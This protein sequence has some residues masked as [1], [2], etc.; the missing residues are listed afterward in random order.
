M[1]E[2]STHRSCGIGNLVV[3]GR[4]AIKAILKQGLWHCVVPWSDS[5]SLKMTI[6]S[7]CQSV[8]EHEAKTSTGPAD[9]G[10]ARYAL[11]SRIPSHWHILHSQVMSPYQECHSH[12]RRLFLLRL[13]YC[14]VHT[15]LVSPR[16]WERRVTAHST[17]LRAFRAKEEARKPN[18]AL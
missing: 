7:I 5:E 12:E 3:L 16:F 6:I 8:D 9:P 11:E 13:W 14:M 15:V 4:T 17:H 2:H 10:D 1:T 18:T